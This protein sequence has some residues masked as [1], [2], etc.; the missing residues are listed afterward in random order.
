MSLGPGL[1]AAAPLRHLVSLPSEVLGTG[2][3]A[4]T[5]YSTVREA[6][7]LV[8]PGARVSFAAAVA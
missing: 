2:R 1:V 8:L 5:A 6:Q 4:A 3:L 7:A